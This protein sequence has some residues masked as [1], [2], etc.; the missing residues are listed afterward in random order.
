MGHPLDGVNGKIERADYHLDALYANL[1][2]FLAGDPYSIVIEPDGEHFW[3][4][5]VL[6]VRHE[7]PSIFGIIVGDVVHNLRSALDHLIYQIIVA[8][9]EKPTSKSC[10]PVYVNSDMFTRQVSKPREQERDSALLGLDDA[11]F[12]IIEKLQPYNGSNPQ[13]NALWLL[14][15]LSNVDK[16]SVVHGSYAVVPDSKPEIVSSGS[17]VIF[18][19]VLHVGPMQEGTPVVRFRMWETTPNSDVRVH[20]NVPLD[21]AIGDVEV[22]CRDLWTIRDSV[23]GIL[24][25]FGS[26]FELVDDDPTPKETR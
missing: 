25:Y 24:N 16:H 22:H 3:Y 2:A 7:P 8:R 10:F 15:E 19:Q 18:E 17:D 11:T 21:V 26:C 13:R 14:H 12:D 1:V 6:R 5:G 4:K 23:V 20:C 9:D